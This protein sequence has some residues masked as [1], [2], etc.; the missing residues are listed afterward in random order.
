[1][2]VPVND[3]ADIFDA[4]IALP[5]EERSAYLEQACRGDERL[6]T[7]VKALLDAHDRADQVLL[8]PPSSSGSSLGYTLQG[9]FSSDVAGTRIG[10]YTLSRMIAEGGMGVVY[11]AQQDNP[12]RSVALKIMKAGVA[13]K[14][15]MRRFEFETQV[16]GRLQ[17]PNIA[18]IHDAGVHDGE[19]GPV[20]YF[21]MELIENAKTIIDYADDKSLDSKARLRLFAR[22]CRAV[23]H[24]HLKG[25]IH[26]DLKPGN[27]LVD[28]DGEPKI[29]DFGVARA[30]DSDVNLT[31]GHTETGKVIGTLAYMSPEQAG[32]R[33]DE[34][35]TRS[36][37]Y[38]LG[39]LLF[40]LLSGAL[41]Y[42]LEER[43][44][45]DAVR[46]IQE[47]EPAALGSIRAA[48][49]G[50]VETIVAKAIEKEPKRRYQSANE[51]AA[52]I[53]RYLSNE[54]IEARP[55]TVRYQL[56]K[57]ARRNRV[58]VA[59]AGV[60]AAVLIAA[61]AVSIGFALSEAEQRR[62]ADDLARSEA[63]QRRIAEQDQAIAE[64]ISDFLTKDLLA[65]VA[66]S[67]E[68]GRGKDVLMRDVL[69]EAAKRIE[70]ASGV[71]GRFEEM[72]LVQASIRAIL[73]RTYRRLGKY[74]ESQKHMERA[75]LLSRRELGEEHPNTHNLMSELATLHM[76]QGRFD[77]C[78]LMLVEALRIKQRVLGEEHPDTVGTMGNLAAVYHRQGKYHEAGPMLSTVLEIHERL[79]GE[80]DRRTLGSLNNLATLY[81]A[82]KRYEKAE[83]LYVKTL[84]LMRRVLGEEHK[85]TLNCANNLASV[86]K[87]QGRYD[88]A[89][90][91]SDETLDILT[92][93]WGETH[94]STLE[95]VMELAILYVAQ[96]RHAEAELLYD[97]TLE[98][99]QR[100]TGETYPVTLAI[101]MNLADLY[102]S[103]GR[104]DEAE[105][106]Y[107]K[108][109]QLRR[110]DLR[111]E[112]PL[113]LHAMKSVA[114]VYASQGRMEDARPLLREM[115]EAK[116][117]RAD[118]PQAS[119]SDK[120]DLAWDL[121]TC[122][123]VDLRDPEVALR[124]AGAACTM[125]NNANLGFLDTLALAQHL[126]G[127][128]PAAIE[129]E[130]TALLL[131][132]PDA[133][134]RGDY[135]AALAK[136]EAALVEEDR[137][138][139]QNGG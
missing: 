66:P 131:L 132:A 65:A 16:L 72:P 115:L 84:A 93:I 55:A 18:H 88:E 75:L 9:G 80:E 138:E 90:L 87:A 134:G 30:T 79:H 99:M 26:R 62:I 35:D 28:A 83:P 78:E 53:R 139:E 52:D 10:R 77:K 13:T 111:Q 124:L 14:S 107:F 130:K 74:D 127:D 123:P 129:T 126:T 45:H 76:K 38:S 42:A 113:T 121:L 46:I 105:P 50:D 100:E 122:E 59:A 6:A 47:D 49:R 95:S 96:G 60:L 118:R 27:V 82:Q 32:G 44:M 117:R 3:I 63:E 112:H 22:V 21:V 31:T 54:P 34:L 70:E 86:Y 17:H 108:V 104:Y 43:A 67:S 64:A 119:P 25:V 125:T 109:L 15:V 56:A 20:P 73:G 120:N 135:E 2:K 133:P 89:E 92:S 39:V 128:T 1:M 116:R 103:Q 101:M 58:V 37:V 7:R 24:G 136:F 110:D 23:H 85:F 137:V 98:T 33:M 48:L 57:F 71:G 51:F 61:T 36:D 4:A 97:K 5:S 69:D 114:S 68:P 19:F 11:E 106:L 29:I 102:R 8:K 12:R 41:P 81:Y 91:L 40:E 94:P